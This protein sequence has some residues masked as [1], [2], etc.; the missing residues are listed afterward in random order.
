MRSNQLRVESCRFLVDKVCQQFL[1]ASLISLCAIIGTAN[2]QSFC[3]EDSECKNP[4]H[5]NC[6]L[7]VGR[8][9]F[10]MASILNNNRSLNTSRN[11]SFCARPTG[12]IN[13][14]ANA[15]RIAQ[16]LLSPTGNALPSGDCS[17]CP[18][19]RES[20]ISETVCLR[21]K[22]WLTLFLPICLTASINID[23]R[24]WHSFWKMIFSFV[25]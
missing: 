16:L 17:N 4:Q 18:P 9:S 7:A 20:T 1:S 23:V 5:P 2:N 8:N 6:P 3:C 22:I 19:R 24:S 25:F 21:H 13:Q 14:G 15:R 12:N 11:S 10:L